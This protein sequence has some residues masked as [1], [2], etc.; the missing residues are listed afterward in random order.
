MIQLLQVNQSTS[1]AD[2]SSSEK[3]K[4]CEL[5]SDSNVEATATFFCVECDL[6]IC[7]RCSTSHKKIKLTRSHQVVP[8]KEIASLEDRIKMTIK[9]CQEHPDRPVE[10]YCYDCKTITCVT[11][12]VENH[13][14][15]E[16]ADIKKS[17]EKFNEQLKEDISN[18]S[19]CV[20]RS[21]TNVEEIEENKKKF[22]EKVKATQAEISKLMEELSAYKI[23]GLKKIECKKDEMEHQIV[24]MESFI[25]YCQEMKDKGTA[26][27]IS[28]AANDLHARAEEL[29]KI[30]SEKS[31][32]ES[33]KVEMTFRSKFAEKASENNYIG[34]LFLDG[35]FSIQFNIYFFRKKQVKWLKVYIW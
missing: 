11:C 16:C 17:A 5:C 31:N 34:E 20:V 26:C 15:H 21:R 18:V 35:W 28:R 13:N 32:F 23:I 8:M 10:L 12:Y 9:Y 2:K 19:T 25:R 1:A 33:C 3:A 24:I 22:V 7:D 30:E 14:K 6:S 4:F 27:D 29:V